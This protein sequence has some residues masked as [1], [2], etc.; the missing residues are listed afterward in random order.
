MA[1]AIDDFLLLITDATCP[2]DE[3]DKQLAREPQLPVLHITGQWPEL[4]PS[5]QRT[6][7]APPFDLDLVGQCLQKQK[8][9]RSRNISPWANMRFFLRNTA[10][11]TG[12][13]RQTCQK[14]RWNCCFCSTKT[15]RTR[16][17]R[18]RSG[19]SSGQSH[20]RART[21]PYMYTSTTY[22]SISQT[23]T[24]SLYY[25]YM[26]KDSAWNAPKIIF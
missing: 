9:L 13:V 23:M 8:S 5:P 7:I 15:V 21:A 4:T 17:P 26:G 14:K 1:L 11:D 20:R 25:P 12:T 16:F 10:Y 22:G 2:D 19:I 3:L 18:R 6:H 24:P